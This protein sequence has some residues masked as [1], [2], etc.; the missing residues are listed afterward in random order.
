MVK[1][2]GLNNV[3]SISNGSDHLAL[4][5]D[6]TVWTIERNTGSEPT[7]L[8]EHESATLGDPIPHLEH[9]VKVD[10]DGEI[11]IAID[12]EGKVWIF[13]T[14]P[15]WVRNDPTFFIAF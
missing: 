13:E 3:I 6:G 7:D 14:A 15:R 5:K 4:R 12:K 9:I 11:G 2:K 1:V 10:A 8:N